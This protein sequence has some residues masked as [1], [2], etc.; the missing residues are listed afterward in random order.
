MANAGCSW[1]TWCVKIKANRLQRFLY[2]LLLGQVCVPT[3][4]D[5]HLGL[6]LVRWWS[7]AMRICHTNWGGNFSREG[8]LQQVIW[9]R[10]YLNR[11]E[12]WLPAQVFGYNQRHSLQ[13]ILR[14]ERPRRIIDTGYC[15]TLSSLLEYFLDLRRWL[16]VK[17]ASCLLLLL[18]ISQAFNVV[19]LDEAFS[20]IVV[21]G[22]HFD[23]KITHEELLLA[24]NCL[25]SILLPL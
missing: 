11:L 23:F 7:G 6:V 22:L 20:Q 19:L 16:E 2:L 17:L 13:Y 15:L 3:L 8:A 1:G 10:I 18:S 21:A 25:G 24:L 12:C 5:S 14:T 9:V 4:S